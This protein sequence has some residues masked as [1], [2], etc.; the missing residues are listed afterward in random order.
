MGDEK[1]RAAYDQYGSASQQAGFDPNAFAGRG[2]FGAGGFGGFQ[3][4]AQAFGSNARG[5][6]DLF[7]TI[8]GSAFGGG[9]RP[10]ASSSP[11]QGE[12]LESS[13]N[14]S[15]VDACKGTSRTVNVTPIVDCHTCS[16]TGL[17]KGSHRSACGTC[18]GTGTRTFVI[19]SGFQMASTC[20]TCQGTGTVV[21][22][23][24]QCGSCDGMG[25][26]K[27]RKT[28][29]VKVPSGMHI[30]VHMSILKSSLT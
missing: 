23:G 18:G 12:D 11:S 13:L 27:E 30:R 10:R 1:K 21:P 7:E 26:V 20:N 15:F 8:F 16:G 6:A 4:F 25:K 22:K 14:L 28:V 2:P 9:G 19:D 17:K 3:D 5:Q 29:E 24:S